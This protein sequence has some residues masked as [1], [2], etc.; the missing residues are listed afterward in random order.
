M[1]DYN[2]GK[3]H[4]YHGWN[5][6]VHLKS[7]VQTFFIYN[8]GDPQFSGDEPINASLQVWENVIAFRVVKEYREPREFWIC[9]DENPGHP[10]FQMVQDQAPTNPNSWTEVIHVREVLE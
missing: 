9:T 3:W 6:P 5:C 10:A 7:Q 2:D 8:G 4:R 1:T